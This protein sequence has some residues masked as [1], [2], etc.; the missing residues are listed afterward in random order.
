MGVLV[1]QELEVMRREIDHQQTPARPQHARRLGDRA[2]AVVQKVQHLVD[3][4]A[5]NESF[6]SARS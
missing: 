1:A 3:E 6:G 4:T 5:S 2:R